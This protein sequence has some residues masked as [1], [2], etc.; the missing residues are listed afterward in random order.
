ME[1]P[2]V[3]MTIELPRTIYERLQRLA[4]ERNCEIVELLRDSAEA[5]FSTAGRDQKREAV[6]R[7]ARLDLPVGSWDEME[8]EIIEAATER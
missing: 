4:A 1:E 3:K 2:T 8:Q 6:D 5:R 7:I